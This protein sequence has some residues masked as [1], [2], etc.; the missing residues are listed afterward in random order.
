MNIFSKLRPSDEPVSPELLQALDGQA[1]DTTG[2]QSPPAEPAPVQTLSPHALRL[3]DLPARQP[4]R[5]ES[6]QEILDHVAKLKSELSTVDAETAKQ[7]H[8]AAAVLSAHT[9]N[10]RAQLQRAEADLAQYQAELQAQQQEAER[11]A[12]LESLKASMVKRMQGAP[13]R[14][15]EL[16]EQVAV[17]N[18]AAVA[19]DKAL[20]RCIVL[21]VEQNS[22]RRFFSWDYNTALKLD[23]ALTHESLDA[24]LRELAGV[25]VGPIRA[26]ASYG[27]A[28]YKWYK[29]HS[30]AAFL[31]RA[32]L[33][34][35]EMQK[36]FNRFSIESDL[37]KWLPE[38]PAQNP[39]NS[40]PPGGPRLYVG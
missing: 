17:M 9:A 26:E 18:E 23:P 32:I 39:A 36:Q 31:A 38:G 3:P 2:D 10:L 24:E 37:E 13:P 30:M 20:W 21:Q 11:Q 7:R 1:Q 25:S 5:S 12:K 40:Q 34:D 8:E 33:K 35:H 15:E 19:F 16:Q 22:S 27:E 14:R 29:V 4:L 28:F 6:E